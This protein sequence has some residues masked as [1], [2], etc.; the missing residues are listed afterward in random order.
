M[1]V[2]QAVSIVAPSGVYAGI[3]VFTGAGVTVSGAPGDKITLR[4]L[5][6]NALG[7]T[8]GVSF[9]SGDAQRASPVG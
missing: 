1:A 3:S 8:S 4:G 9:T 6:I 7:G 5:T 2:S